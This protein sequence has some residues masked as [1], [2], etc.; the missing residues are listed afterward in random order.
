APYPLDLGALAAPWVRLAWNGTHHLLVSRK[1]DGLPHIAMQAALLDRHGS[2]IRG[3]TPLFEL[4]FAGSERLHEYAYYQIASNGQSFFMTFDAGGAGVTKGLALNAF[5]EPLT[6]LFDITKSIGS[7]VTSNGASYLVVSNDQRGLAATFISESFTVGAT[8]M[9]ATDQAGYRASIDWTGREYFMTFASGGGL[10]GTRISSEG[11]WLDTASTPIH[12]QASIGSVTSWSGEAHIVALRV[13]TPG[14]ASYSEAYMKIVRPDGEPLPAAS[15]D[16]ILLSRTVGSQY[17][18]AAAFNGENHLVVWTEDAPGSM[19]NQYG[20]REY[21]VRA[22]R[23][24]FDGRRLDDGIELAKVI[25]GPGAGPHYRPG[26]AVASD[27]KNFLVLWPRDNTLVGMRVSAEG[28]ALDAESFRIARDISFAKVASDGAGFLIVGQ[29]F[30]SSY[31]YGDLVS[32]RVSSSG[33][34]APAVHIADL[35]GCRALTGLSIVWSGSRYLVTWAARNI[36]TES[37]LFFP[38]C[39]D[40]PPDANLQSRFLNSEGFKEGS[41]LFTIP[42]DYPSGISLGWNGTEYLMAWTHNSQ[43]LAR[44]ISAS[45]ELQET[46]PRLF[47]SGVGD[48][49]RVVGNSGGFFYGW[50]NAGQVLVKRITSV[51]LADESQPIV[52]APGTS[53]S[54]LVDAGPRRVAVLYRRLAMEEPYWGSERFFLRFATFDPPRRR[55][56]RP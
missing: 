39:P 17:T 38:G 32:I 30:E 47:S 31:D 52:V 54:T 50:K 35:G 23:I 41:R 12:T 48:L 49:L 1:Q 44:S 27:G 5:G 20:Q 46:T 15:A 28:R 55:P 25:V 21:R 51:A 13:F 16:G 6:K 3:H 9:V 42:F 43:L 14:P 36:K 29:S 53:A 11:K 24:A 4:P 45:G 33:F 34:V 40:V 10:F 18:A 7:L 22:G 2:V 37:Y 19:P 26:V 8:T 56:A